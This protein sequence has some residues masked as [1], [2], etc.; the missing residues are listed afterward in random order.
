MSD[1]KVYRRPLEMMQ[2]YHRHHQTDLEE[3]VVLCHSATS[4]NRIQRL[5]HRLRSFSSGLHGHHTIEDRALFPFLASRA[6]IRHLEAHHLMLGP[7][8]ASLNSLADRL[9]RLKE[10]DGFDKAEAEGTVVKVQALVLEHENAE[11]AVLAADNLKKHMSEEE[12][13]RWMKF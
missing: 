2:Y 9:L 10:V 3:I 12:C 5:A 4:L 7:A 1:M 8:L 13:R 11:E 6:D